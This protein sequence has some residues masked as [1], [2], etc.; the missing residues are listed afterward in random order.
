MNRRDL[1]HADAAD[2]ARRA[3][4]SGPH[5]DLDGIGARGDQIARGFFGGDVS[6]DEIQFRELTLSLP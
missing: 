2:H 5:A 4:R 3:D 1:R 6:D